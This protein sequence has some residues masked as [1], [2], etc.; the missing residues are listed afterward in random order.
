MSGP[1]GDLPG[2]S[3]DPIRNRY[4]PIP[5]GPPS[6]LTE[7]DN[8]PT[9]FP[10][11]PHNSANSDYSLA[12][13]DGSRFINPNSHALP[14]SNPISNLTSN[15]S[16]NFASRG[17]SDSEGGQPGGSGNGSLTRTRTGT[18]TPAVRGSGSVNTN[19]NGTRKEPNPGAF[20][21]KLWQSQ[22]QM[23]GH[24]GDETRMRNLEEISNPPPGCLSGSHHVK[25]NSYR[26]GGFDDK[27]TIERVAKI[28]KGRFGI[29][30][31]GKTNDRHLSAQENI[32]SNLELEEE[33]N[34]CGCHGEV[35]TDYKAF[36]DEA[37]YA[38][39]DHGKVIMHNRNGNT[40]IFS[41]CAQ[42]LVGMHCD[43]PRLIMM[44][45]AGGSE[46]HVHLF[47]RD[48][49]MLE[50]VFMTHSELNL[51]QS[52]IYGLS[53]FDDICTL[54]GIKSITTIN[55]SGPSL[56]SSRRKLSSDAL[57]VHQ[58]SKDLVYV[59]QRSGD[60]SLEDLRTNPRNPN[61]VART[62]KGKA[63]VEV[64]RLS[65]AA[66]P[67]GVIVSG[68][69][70]EMLLFDVR[71]GSEPLKVFKGHFNTFHSS[72]ALATT[73]DDKLLFASSSDRR[74]RAWSTLTGEPVLPPLSNEWELHDEHAKNPL[75]KVFE[76]RITHLDINDEL[77]LDAV[78]RGDLY[79][80]GRA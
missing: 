80:F 58:S 28:K 54:G 67:W 4:F 42:N 71:Y 19:G 33:H 23:H 13:S 3:F 60:V 21:S 59:G 16:S 44:A 17:N 78:V 66:V 74:I 18:G 39:T 68:M 27:E 50:H 65:D 56:R 64:K 26:F 36:G 25:R 34:H 30:Y 52:E 46:P 32:L 49:E 55:Y 1:L 41:V 76:H 20:G 24:A 8:R 79:R 9:P 40:A 6:N 11:Y 75:N 22:N 48:P 77:G 35:I 5:R 72:V 69:S 53:G 57:A 70:H 45:I 2:M 51:Y 7:E 37:Y 62:V 43:T 38:T 47:K 15:E 29:R 31:N 61:V 63:V 10:T 73:S 14:R 12:R